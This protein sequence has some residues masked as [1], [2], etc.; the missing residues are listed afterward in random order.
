MLA[1]TIFFSQMVA[2]CRKK[3]GHVRKGEKGKSLRR[4]SKEKWKDKITG[5]TLCYFFI[6]I[7]T[8]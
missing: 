8:K 2:K 4:W 3:H 6:V 7:F 5:D 1:F